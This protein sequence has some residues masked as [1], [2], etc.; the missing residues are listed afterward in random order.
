MTVDKRWTVADYVRGALTYSRPASERVVAASV[1]AEARPL[2]AQALDE[3]VAQGVVAF[4]G[5]KT[6]RTYRL[7][8]DH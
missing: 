2:V 5:P 8:K 3:L 7:I 6:R 4:D 1:P